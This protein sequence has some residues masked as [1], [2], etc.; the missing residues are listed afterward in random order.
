MELNLTKKQ[1]EVFADLSKNRIVICGRRGGKTWFVI[2]EVLYYLLSRKCEI[3]YTAPTYSQ[4][5]K[6]FWTDFI[7][8]V[9]R[10]LIKKKS[11][12]ELTISFKNGSLLTIASAGN[13]DRLRGGRY[14]YIYI[15]EGQD[16]MKEAYN[17]L[18]PTIATTEGHIT[19]LGT[20]KGF[21]WITELTNSDEWSFKSW[22][23]AE[24]GLVSEIEIERAKRELD[25]RTFRQ[26]YLAEFLSAEGMIFYAFDSESIVD[27]KFDKNKTVYLSF[28]FNVNPMT[29]ILFQDNIAVKEFEV[30]HSNTYD[31][32][33]KIIRYLES[34]DYKSL[35]YITGDNTGNSHK[36][37][38]TK[39]DY[40]IIQEVFKSYLSEYNWKKT[41]VV[42][43]IEDRFNTTNSALITWSGDRKLFINRDCEKLIKYLSN[44]TRADYKNDRLGMTHLTDC[45]TYYAYNYLPIRETRIQY[46]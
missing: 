15:D 10:Y 20:P 33:N 38:A 35:V 23:T 42:V 29:C 17:T 34:Q 1:S 43:N 24:G 28:D 14:N 41:K 18:R 36:T 45:F 32:S 19:I 12:S 13:Y 8:I 16:T 7:S 44:I 26:E 11:E 37:S 25:E 46:I 39:T 6:I 31:L 40:Q 21:S 5:K 9:P 27:V 3:L 30:K 2:F 4:A 22:T